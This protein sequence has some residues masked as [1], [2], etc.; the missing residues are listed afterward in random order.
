MTAYPTISVD[1]DKLSRGFL[2]AV[3]FC[4][5]VALNEDNNVDLSNVGFVT[6]T[7]L[8][9][10]RVYLDK[11]PAEIKWMNVNSYL[12]TM[13]FNDGGIDASVMRNTEFRTL[14]EKYIDKRYIPIIRFPTQEEGSDKRDVILSTIHAILNKQCGFAANVDVGLRYV[15]GE[16]ADNIIEHSHSPYGYITTQ[17]YQSKGFTD[18]CIA[19]IG[20]TILGSYSENPRTAGIDTDV[21]ALQSAVAGISTKNLP[22]AENRGFGLRTT[23]RMLT[24]GLGGEFLLASGGAA[25]AANP[26]NEQYIELPSGIKFSGTIIAFRVNH[27]FNSFNY[28]KYVE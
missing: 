4:A 8:L 10:V 12:T 7:F 11:R 13:L 15:I 28:L 18:I 2:S 14:M 23:I 25:F 9:P 20:G 22:E 6:P 5:E 3:R 26:K 16:I 24:K 1:D 17:S 19:D 27:N 21:E